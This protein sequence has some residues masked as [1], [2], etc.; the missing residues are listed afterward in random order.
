MKPYAKI[1]DPQEASEAFMSGVAIVTASARL[2]GDEE[3]SKDAQ[4]LGSALRNIGTMGDMSARLL[5]TASL[6][7]GIPVGIISH[8]IS[9]RMSDEQMRQKQLKEEAGYYR[10]ATS[11]IEREMVRQ[12]IKTSQVT[13]TVPAGDGDGQIPAARAAKA[14]K[15]LKLTKFGPTIAGSNPVENGNQAKDT[16]S[17]PMAQ[18]GL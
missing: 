1:L 3:L 11:G 18:G 2:Y 5:V 4:D 17:M 14:V 13:S 12:G 8:V 16:Q 6:M 7:T 9:K 15:A 10:G